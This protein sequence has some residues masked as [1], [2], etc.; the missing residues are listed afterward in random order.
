M[1][2]MNGRTN[3]FELPAVDVT[4]AMSFYE[5][6][7]G[8]KFSALRDNTVENYWVIQ[9]GDALIGGLRQRAL[10]NAKKSESDA[11]VI[12]F[13]VATL[14]TAVTRARELGAKMVGEPVDIGGGRGCFQLLRDREENLIA[15]WA[16][17]QSQGA[18]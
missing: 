10:P 17:E 6:L 15:L 9:S 8:W 5:G 1:N 16:K 4:N 11:P 2:D 12:Y 7:F 3:W 14:D 13:N 18:L